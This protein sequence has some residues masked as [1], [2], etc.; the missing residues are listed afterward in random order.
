MTNTIAFETEWLQPPSEEDAVGPDRFTWGRLLI[1]V[2]ATTATNWRRPGSTEHR[3]AVVGGMA[4]LADWIVECWPSLLFDA[5]TP[6]PKAE[7]RENQPPSTREVLG[8]QRLDGEVRLRE[9]GRWE[10]THR[11]GHG[12]TDL[13]LP[14]VVFV[15]EPRHVGV[16]VGPEPL[17]SGDVRF[18]ETSATA[19]ISRPALEEA[20]GGFVDATIARARTSAETAEWAEWL[21]GRWRSQRGSVASPNAQ[22]RLLLGDLQAEY[23]AERQ[24]DLGERTACLVDA[25]YDLGA[26]P[27]RVLGDVAGAIERTS[28]AKNG[29]TRWRIE[30][31]FSE[32][33]PHEQ[34]YRLAREIRSRLDKPSEP[35]E[36]LRAALEELGVAVDDIPGGERRFRSLAMAIPG[37][38]PRIF[39]ALDADVGVAPSRFSILAALGRLV[40]EATATSPWGAAYGDYARVLPSKRAGAFAAEFLL[41]REAIRARGSADLQKLCEDFGISR[42]AATWHLHNVTTDQQ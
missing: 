32:L 24:T 18:G 19:W 37:S 39:R 40:S 14:S 41:P 22:Q 6:F 30:D 42:S 7:L 1:Q 12:S 5:P 36:D 31:S 33:P 34:G 11:L 10:H 2:G 23:I 13:A 16:F 3:T 9:L 21:D 4:G 8:G 28:Q 15:P 26:A 17:P 35:I 25:T 20:L 27:I 29:N 38:R